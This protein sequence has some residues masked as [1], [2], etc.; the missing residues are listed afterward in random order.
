MNNFS[1]WHAASL[2]LFYFLKMSNF[3][4]PF[5]LWL[6]WRRDRVVIT[7]LLGF[8]LSL[9]V[10][11][12]NIKFDAFRVNEYLKTERNGTWKE[13]IRK[14]QYFNNKILF[15][16]GSLI[17]MIVLLI[18]FSLLIFSLWQHIRQMM[19]HAKGSGDFNTGL[20][21]SQ[22]YYDFFHH[23]LLCALFF[24]YH[25]TLVLLLNRKLTIRIIIC[26]TVALL[27][28]SIHPIHM[29]LG[30]RKLR[31]TAMNLLRQ[32]S[33]ASRDRDPSQ[34]AGTGNY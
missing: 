9:F 28:P 20:C 12:L 15:S 6:K 27:Y 10:S 21:E 24:H 33:P 5:F 14:P 11:L 32:M 23:S 13:Y 26:E 18:S 22:K 31:Q 34:N 19:H 4:H 29:I 30:N 25:V 3:S 7:I 17:P 1:T 2:S 16:L 8:F